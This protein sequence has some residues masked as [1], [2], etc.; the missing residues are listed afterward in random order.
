MVRAFLIG[1]AVLLLV[2]GCAG[3]RSESPQEGKGPTEA[4]KKEQGRSPQATESEQAR[5]E[6]TRTTR[7][8]PHS[9]EYLTND[10]PGCPKGGL[11]SGTD[12][13]DHLAGGK[14][15]DEVRGLGTEDYIYGGSG[16]D[17]IY[18]GAGGDDPPSRNEKLVGGKG[19]DVIY[20]GDGYDFIRAR[21]DRGRDKLY[22]GKGRDYYDA[23]KMDFVDRSCEKEL[24][25]IF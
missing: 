18:G 2:V 17:V 21:W 20:G 13:Y 14:G 19:E 16:N 8:S 6:G 24:K 5:C 9:T 7:I 3:T 4:A 23:D 25:P 1:C 11:L 22:C 12:K 15:D 10:V